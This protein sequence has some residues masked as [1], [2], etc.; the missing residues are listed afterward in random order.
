MMLSASFYIIACSAKNRLLVRLRRL[1][2]PRYMLGAIAGAAYL[3]FGVFARIG[4]GRRPVR[5]PPSELSLGVGSFWPSIGGAVLL[6][7]AGLAWVSPGGSGLFDFSGAEV[8]FLFP[9]PVSR[10]Q[11]LVHRIARSQLGLLFAAMV[12]AFLITNPSLQIGSAGVRVLRG[13]ALWVI[14]LTVRVYVAGV[15]LARARLTTGDSRARRVAWTPLLTTIAALAVAGVPLVRSFMRE[16]VG[17]A[18][19]AMSRFSSV[20]STGLP[21]IVL[22]PFVSLVR[23]LFSEW[24]GPFLLAMAGSLTVMVVTVVWVL[25]SDE[26]FQQVAED[27]R[28][29]KERSQASSM[30]TPT[31]RDVGWSLGLSGRTETLFLWKNAMQTLRGTKLMTVLPFAIP[32]TFL[33]VASA[34]ARMSPG[35]RGPAAAFATVSLALA[36]FCAFLGPQ[37]MRGDLRG[38]LPHLE[39][40]K[41]WPVK[42]A[43]VIRGEILWPTTLLTLCAWLALAC[44]T[45]FSTAAFPALTLGSRLSRSAAAFLLAP[46]LI[47]AQ[48]AVHNAAAVLFPA[49]VATGRDRPRGLDAMGQRL[50]L[51][52]G[53]MLS[54]AVLVG[55]GAIAGGIVIFALYRLIGDVSLVA[56]AVVCLAIVVIEVLLVTEML[57]GVYDRIDLS[58][59]ERSE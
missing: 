57:G 17:S 41:T 37:A 36:A 42:A 33:A 4:A 1:R 30:S 40:L 6:V 18:D 54:L 44:G 50:I 8:Q 12:P 11:L 45:I 52:G 24:P 2:E 3:Y 16:P 49:W 14:F 21:R 38:D 32:L 23:P 48:L 43:A 35:T 26:A 34:T 59:V 53:V 29:R 5:R 13:L 28:R 19:E 58:Q 22:W 15:M 31:S 47:V 56:A 27:T 10:R 39:Q 9:A 7:L 46:A 25:S 51:F 55:P 20:V